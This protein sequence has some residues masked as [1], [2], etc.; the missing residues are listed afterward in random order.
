MNTRENR[1]TLVHQDIDE[2]IRQQAYELWQQEGCPHGRA[3]DH[4]L[5]AGEIVHRRHKEVARIRLRHREKVP[6]MNLTEMVEVL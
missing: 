3:L 2:Q 1:Q 4:W 5:T 6:L